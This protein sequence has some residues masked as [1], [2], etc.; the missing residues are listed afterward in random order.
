MD[1]YDDKDWFRSS[2]WTPEIAEAFEAKLAR[3]RA[4][5]RAQYV[6]IQAVHLV[7]Q[8]DEPSRAAG[9]ALFQRVISDYGDERMQ[10]LSA[11]EQ[12]GMAFS[13][14]GDL[15]AAEAYL[16]Q[17]LHL[18]AESPTGR[19]GT[20]GMTEV[21]LAEILV[22]KDTAADA[23][24][25]QVLLDAV[26]PEI[27]SMGMF[28]NVALRYLVARARVAH[29]L[30]DVRAAVYASEALAVA[31]E[32]EPSIPRH[33]DLGRPVV[34]PDLLREMQRLA[35]IGEVQP[36]KVSWLRRVVKSARA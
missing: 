2:R 34:S 18:I 3:A 17:T 10:A 20:T 15:H 36:P 8:A 35:G 11:T 24:G 32:T 5:N 30:D 12:L 16:R 19:S 22:V 26:E 21:L 9:R 25:A 29:Q 4:W 23:Q 1:K 31:A 27:A 14:A 7:G 6:R 13:D 28:R 33:P